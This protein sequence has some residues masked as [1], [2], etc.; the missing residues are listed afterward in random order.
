MKTF[1]LVVN[2]HIT[3]TDRQLADAILNNGIFTDRGKAWRHSMVLNRQKF[4]DFMNGEED[5]CAET[6]TREFGTLVTYTVKAIDAITDEDETH[7]G[8]PLSDMYT[9][10]FRQ[11]ADAI[12]EAERNYGDAL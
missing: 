10:L 4:S 2:Q 8:K 1:Y 9:E 6:V 3:D 7:E 5:I 12:K 11:A